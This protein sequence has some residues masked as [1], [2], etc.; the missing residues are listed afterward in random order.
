VDARLP[1]AYQWLLV[2]CQ[3]SPQAP[4]QWQAYRLTGADHLAARASKKL[5][6]EDL[7][8]PSFAGTMLRRELDKIPLW[9]GDHVSIRQLA[10]DFARYIYLPRLAGPEVL[11]NAARDGVALL[12]WAQDRF[13]YADSYDGAT[14][15]Y[16]GLRCAQRFD[17]IHHAADGLLVKPEIAVKQLEADQAAAAAVGSGAAP[18][19]GA[20][21]TG[22]QP[23]TGSRGDL[24]T[25]AGNGGTA[26][27][28]PNRFYGTVTLDAARVGRDAGK[29]AEEVIAHLAGLVGAKVTVTLEIEAS[30][31]DGV[32]ENVVR[33]VTENGRT[34]SFTSQGF[35]RE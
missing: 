5:R 2:P 9:R 14:G 20:A 34:L 16:R 8:A 15:R 22:G 27:P 10:D 21:A 7:L 18:G 26:P 23:P 1:E 31:P 12:S 11:S 25:L 30:V 24:T 28:R 17:L 19:A 13:A 32:P 35:D 33:T 3:A 4:M 29:I 6:S